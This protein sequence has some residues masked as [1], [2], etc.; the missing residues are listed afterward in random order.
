LYRIKAQGYGGCGP[1]I[2]PI[3]TT[4]LDVA[5]NEIADLLSSDHSVQLYVVDGDGIETRI[6]F[7][8]Y[9]TIA[10]NIEELRTT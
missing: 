7:D 1:S 9:T 6:K 10:V 3:E 5:R 4:S 2:C 8:Y